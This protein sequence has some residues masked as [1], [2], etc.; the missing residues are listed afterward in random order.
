MSTVQ[1]RVLKIL[2]ERFMKRWENRHWGHKSFEPSWEMFNSQP[3]GFERFNISGEKLV[4]DT[5]DFDTVCYDEIA[6]RIKALLY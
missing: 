3:E 5:T 4:I 6:G 2:F 1:V